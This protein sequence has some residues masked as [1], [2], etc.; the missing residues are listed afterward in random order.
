MDNVNISK[1]N[2]KIGKKE[3]SLTLEAAKEL[4]NEYKN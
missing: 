1:I 4:Q 2:I 3:I